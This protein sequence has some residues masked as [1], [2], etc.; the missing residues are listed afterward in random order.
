MKVK[1]E[2]LLATF[3]VLG[4]AAAL[5]YLGSDHAHAD[6]SSITLQIDWLRDGEGKDRGYSCF[7]EIAVDAGF[8][9]LH[10]CGLQATTQPGPAPHGLAGVDQRIHGDGMEEVAELDQVALLQ[11]RATHRQ[12]P[13]MDI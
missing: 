4:I 5:A 3:A 2:S 10:D 6:W 13:R 1:E 12:P 9:A 8:G 11:R 7:R